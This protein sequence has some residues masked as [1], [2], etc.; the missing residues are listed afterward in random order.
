MKNSHFVWVNQP[1]SNVAA[2]QQK[3]IYTY[4]VESPKELAAIGI[5]GIMIDR[6][7]AQTAWLRD[8]YTDWEWDFKCPEFT[9][10]MLVKKNNKKT[11]HRHPEP[12]L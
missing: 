6:N 11:H 3:R 2:R 5:V 4:S 12:K 1:N 7:S 9:L 8:I 10:H